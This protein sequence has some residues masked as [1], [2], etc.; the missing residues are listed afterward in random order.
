M[1]YLILRSRNLV[2]SFHLYCLIRVPGAD[3]IPY[4]NTIIEF[5]Y[6]KIIN[7]NKLFLDVADK[8]A[9]VEVADHDNQS[10]EIKW[11]PPKNDGGAPIQKYIIQKKPK[12]GDWENAAEV[13]CRI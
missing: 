8:P 7:I 3:Q 6:V 10:A 9:N 5:Y 2:I 4:I 13:I 1:L 12:G 11:D